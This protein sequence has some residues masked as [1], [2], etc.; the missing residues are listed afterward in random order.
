MI[1]SAHSPKNQ[2]EVFGFRLA[3]GLHGGLAL[4]IL[5]SNWILPSEPIAIL[6]T[7]KVDLVGLPDQLKSEPILAGKAQQLQ[8]AEEQ[9]KRVQTPDLSKIPVAKQPVDEADSGPSLQPAKKK[10]APNDR[11]KKLQASLNRIKSL[12]KI[13]SD[14]SPGVPIRGNRVSQGTSLSSD[15]IQ[16]LQATYFDH[17]RDRLQ[18]HWS[19]PIWL[20]RQNFSAQIQLT[21]DRTG[22]AKSIRWLKRSGNESFDQF[23]QRAIQDSQPFD[24]PPA[25]V[26]DA[27]ESRGIQVGFPL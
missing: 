17:V 24:R 23:V 9:A 12:Q 21:I 8:E 15:A 19:L 10:E 26:A 16:A 1:S 22:R 3:L 5:V 6:P 18:E 13:Q 7:L 11:L 14:E 2:N 20:S 25:D 4:F 27:V